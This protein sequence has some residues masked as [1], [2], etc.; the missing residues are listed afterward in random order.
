MTLSLSKTSLL[1]GV[2]AESLSGEGGSFESFVKN[3]KLFLAFGNMTS[4]FFEEFEFHKV[5]ILSESELKTSNDAP[6]YL[7]KIIIPRV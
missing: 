7:P 4:L 6:T 2:V 3:I 5:L 1:L